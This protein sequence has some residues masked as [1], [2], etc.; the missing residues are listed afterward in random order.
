ML[1]RRA[2]PHGPQKEGGAGQMEDTLAGGIDMPY[3]NS[4]PGDRL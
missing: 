1:S 2:V 3:M 4:E